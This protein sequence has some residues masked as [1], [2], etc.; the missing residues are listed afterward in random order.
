MAILQMRVY[1]IVIADDEMP[2]YCSMAMLLNR[3]GIIAWRKT[4]ASE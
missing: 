3:E 2:K 4:L 1:G